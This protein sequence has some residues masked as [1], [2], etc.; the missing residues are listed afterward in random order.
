MKSRLSFKKERNM[1]KG[2]SEHKK[3][4]VFQQKTI[5]LKTSTKEERI[6]L[7]NLVYKYNNI[8]YRTLGAS[9]TDS[10]EFKLKGGSIP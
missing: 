2:Y 5:Q 10:V 7:Y 9:D 3:D 1:W 8:F 6:N 4:F